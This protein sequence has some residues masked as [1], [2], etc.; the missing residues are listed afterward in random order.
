MCVRGHGGRQG[1]TGRIEIHSLMGT[2]EAYSSASLGMREPTRAQVERP[3]EMADK[4]RESRVVKSCRILH[5]TNDVSE[6]L[7]VAS[8]RATC[9]IHVGSRTSSRTWARTRRTARDA[10]MYVAVFAMRIHNSTLSLNQ[11]N[12]YV[13]PT[14]CWST[15]T[16]RLGRTAENLCPINA[17]IIRY[18]ARRLYCFRLMTEEG[19][20]SSNHQRM[21]SSTACLTHWRTLLRGIVLSSLISMLLIAIQLGKRT[22][23]SEPIWR[24]EGL[25][26]SEEYR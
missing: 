8:D 9:C 20:I 26:R 15:E 21:I 12:A 23:F 22:A 3:R 17:R 24:T 7:L 2:R 6:R 13:I 25:D 16:S 10:P 4:S 18:S 19:F 1:G 14:I 5:P 11:N